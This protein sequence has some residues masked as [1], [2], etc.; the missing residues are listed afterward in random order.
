VGGGVDWPGLT[1][2][3]YV[4]LADQVLAGESKKTPKTLIEVPAPLR[5]I[6]GKVQAQLYVA[7]AMFRGCQTPRTVKAVDAWAG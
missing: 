3:T 7:V 2:T 5:R 1:G 6:V 4:L